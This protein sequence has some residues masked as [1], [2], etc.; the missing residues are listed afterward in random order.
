[1]QRRW[2]EFTVKRKTCRFLAILVVSWKRPRDGQMAVLSDK[3]GR[4]LNK[5]SNKTR[6]LGGHK[7]HNWAEKPRRPWISYVQ[8]REK[9]SLMPSTMKSWMDLSNEPSEEVKRWSIDL[10]KQNVSGT[11]IYIY[12]SKVMV[13]PM[14]L[15][16]SKATDR[17]K[18]HGGGRCMFLSVKSNK[19]ETLP[20]LL[21]GSN[22][23]T[24]WSFPTLKNPR[25]SL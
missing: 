15:V 16:P 6:Q 17:L 3:N 13:H 5:M 2:Q 12:S 21:L 7:R 25:T 19:G 9:S 22:R 18:H 23:R 24:Y 20:V 4:Y 10:L 1:M 14:G 11:S 8:E